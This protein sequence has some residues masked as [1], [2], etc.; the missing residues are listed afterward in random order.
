MDFMSQIS[1]LIKQPDQV[2]E[3]DSL[4]PNERFSYWNDLVCEE[5]VEL[6]CGSVQNPSFYGKILAKDV[7]DLRVSESY[8]AAQTL[9]RKN[10][11]IAKTTDDPIIVNV[12]L[13]GTGHF[14]QGSNEQILAPGD[15]LFNDSTKPFSWHFNKGFGHMILQIPRQ[16]FFERGFANNEAELD[17]LS[18]TKVS[19]TTFYGNS[20]VGFVLDTIRQ[21]G[22]KNLTAQDQSF[23]ARQIWQMLTE[24]LKYSTQDQPAT[25]AYTQSISLDD[26]EQFV[27]R[28]LATFSMTAETISQAFSV[29]PRSV[30]KVF[31]EKNL[32]LAKFIIEKRLEKLA[33]CLMSENHN[34]HKITDLIYECGFTNNT[35]ASNAF[36][37]RFGK[38]PSAFRNHRR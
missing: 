5:F 7:E 31:E 27:E 21:I 16:T 12:Q 10:K 15:F 22:R 23:A 28:N 30:Y 9:T 6:E 8:S 36:K 25:T 38:S 18:G 13:K 14:T 3:V 35:H 33:N 26:I 37:A 4:K 2:I 1:P 32:S 17:N 11:H 29:S 34:R 20:T 24:S 19:G